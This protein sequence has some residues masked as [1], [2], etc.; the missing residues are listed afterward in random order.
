MDKEKTNS[1]AEVKSSKADETKS[2]DKETFESYSYR[3]HRFWKDADGDM[4]YAVHVLMKEDV[5]SALEDYGNIKVGKALRDRI[6]NLSDKEMCFLADDLG[7]ALNMNNYWESLY[8]ILE[9]FLES[10]I[11]KNEKEIKSKKKK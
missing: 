11:K 7:N 6:N 8:T 1:S 3:E 10:D 2:T 9:H 4:E 5:I